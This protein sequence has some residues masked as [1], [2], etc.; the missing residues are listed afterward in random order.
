MGKTTLI[1]A[2]NLGPTMALW[3][4][5][6][7]YDYAP[8]NAPKDGL[9][10]LS[11]TQLLKPTKALILAQQ[12]PDADN[13]VELESLASSRI[14]QS[15]HMAIEAAFENPNHDVVLKSLGFPGGLVDKL[16]LNP[17]PEFMKE[18]PDAIPVYLE[19]R[20]YRKIRTSAGTWVWI[21]GKFDQVIAGRPEDNKSTKVYSYIKMDQTEKGNYA[22]QMAMYRW[23][24]PDIITSDVGVINFI[25]TDWKA[26]EAGRTPNYP[27][28]PVME[29]PVSLMSE[30]DAERFIRAKL[31][32][33]EMNAGKP[34]QD[35]IR[36]ADEELW[37]APDVFKYYANEDVA[38]AN[39]RATKNFETMAQALAFKQEKG[40]GVIV[41]VPGE[42]KRCS[43]CDAA[44][45]CEQRLEYQTD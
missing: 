40:K 31:D 11:V 18:H 43:Y 45:V 28:R 19:K 20:A 39:G 12:V 29:M 38:K 35:M 3:L 8:A 26:N 13:K 7:T 17:S 4:A 10:I 6:D 34:Q 2:N 15:I 9:P 5:T 30:D 41:T 1:N 36:C 16:K 21:S 27:P 23:L 37:R 42:V 24:S 22:L 32:E 44:P 25:F 14:G 33:L